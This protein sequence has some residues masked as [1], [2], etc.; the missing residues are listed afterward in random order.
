M[1][2]VLERYSV[3]P[4]ERPVMLCD[5]T[6]P[7]SGD[8]AALEAIKDLPVD[9]IS[10]AYN[11]GKLVRAD[12]AAVAYMIGERLGLE[13]VFSLAPRDMNKIA[14]QSRLLGAQMLGLENVLV[15]QGD[16][17]GER[18]FQHGVAESHDFTSTSLIASIRD[19]NDGKDYRDAELRGATSFCIGA[20]LDM[21]RSIEVEARLAAR[22][23][24]AGA[25]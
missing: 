24:E 19:L 17:L 23:I 10:V 2:T 8:P 11:P 15:L 25:S 7:R 6:P 18:E 1:T 21:S 20:T 14:L 3:T 16:P 5:F 4:A 13:S 22:K 9:F 12:S